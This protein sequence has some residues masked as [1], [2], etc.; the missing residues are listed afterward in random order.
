MVSH[1]LYNPVYSALTTG[2]QHLGFGTDKVKS[3]HEDVSPFA[4]FETGY[5]NGFDE[6][7]ALYPRSRIIL[8]ATPEHIDTPKGWKLIDKIEGVQMIHSKKVEPVSVNVELV[9]LGVQHVEQMIRLARLTKP[10]PFGTRTIEFG[11][12]YGVIL[13]DKIV[14]MTGQRMHIDHFTEISAVCTHPDHLGKG[15][16]FALV[17][18]QLKLIHDQGKQPILHVRADNTRAINIYE[19]LG[20]TISRGMNFYLLKK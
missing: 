20:F 9:P 3:F 1:L 2:D 4:S 16:A 15:Y 13:N 11:H 19:R 7:Y 18:H 6:L 12:Y 17:Q 10:G 8:Y 5:E 14:A